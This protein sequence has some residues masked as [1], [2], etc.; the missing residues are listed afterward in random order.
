MVSWNAVKRVTERKCWPDAA[1]RVASGSSCNAKSTARGLGRRFPHRYPFIVLKF[2]H[3]LSA[4]VFYVLGTSFFVAYLGVR[5]NV[6]AP[7]SLWWLNV[8]DLPLLISGLLYGASSVILSITDHER[9]SVT[10]IV[11]VLL[12]AAL[13]LL[14]VLILNFGFLS[15]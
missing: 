2:L 4:W 12:P 1:R 10:A 14:A 9:P 13:I 8:L 3:Q 7:L 15:A 6:A 5:Q 11:S